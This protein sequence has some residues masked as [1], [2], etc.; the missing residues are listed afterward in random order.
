M[1]GKSLEECRAQLREDMNYLKEQDLLMQKNSKIETIDIESDNETPED[2]KKIIIPGLGVNVT[3]MELR[4][5]LNC[6]NLNNLSHTQPSK[7]TFSKL[8]GKCDAILHF[9][10]IRAAEDYG[11]Q[12]NQSLLYSVFGAPGL[13]SPGVSPP[14]F[15]DTTNSIHIIDN[16]QTESSD[17]CQ[18][19]SLTKVLSNANVIPIFVDIQSEDGLY[20]TKIKV[21]LL[22]HGKC[23]QFFGQ[24]PKI[25]I[26]AFLNYM[27]KYYPSKEGLELVFVTPCPAT[28]TL[29][30]SVLK[31]NVVNKQVFDFYFTVWTDIQSVV[32]EAQAGFRGI[33][34]CSYQSDK[35]CIELLKLLKLLKL[36]ISQ[37]MCPHDKASCT[38]ECICL[39]ESVVGAC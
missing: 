4:R 35:G 13:S 27:K 7:I 30:Y 9:S 17:I 34:A 39:D 5:S 38:Y 3:E 2:G 19:E 16:I 21:N 11:K 37:M 1:S 24:E 36:L 8:S 20:I 10:D 33:T 14:R 29:F 23:Q 25:L 32:R 6:Q 31:E 15:V 22:T 26:S 28:Y 18:H 12:I